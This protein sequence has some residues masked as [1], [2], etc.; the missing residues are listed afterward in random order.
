M[1]WRWPS[2]LRYSRSWSGPVGVTG[3]LTGQLQTYSGLKSLPHSRH[4]QMCG[5]RQRLL[6]LTDRDSVDL[7]LFAG[8]IGLGLQGR[9]LDCRPNIRADAIGCAQAREELSKP[10]NSCQREKT[11]PCGAPAPFQPCGHS[12]S[13]KLKPGLPSA[14][15]KASSTVSAPVVWSSF[16]K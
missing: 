9:L 11:A 6:V 16:S 14:S 5:V 10:K 1:R 13:A 4:T 3:S 12:R 8:A 2:R 7:L 15:R